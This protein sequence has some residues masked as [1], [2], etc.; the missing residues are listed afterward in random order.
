M[1]DS[2]I[3]NEAILEEE[4]LRRVFVLCSLNSVVYATYRQELNP[5]RSSEVATAIDYTV[6][7]YD[8]VSIRRKFLS[9]IIQSIVDQP[10]VR[11]D[12]SYITALFERW[13]LKLTE[14]QSFSYS[15]SVA[16]RALVKDTTKTAKDRPLVIIDQCPRNDTARVSF[17]VSFLK[18]SLPDLMGD[19]VYECTLP[20]YKQ[21]KAF[22]CISCLT[23]T[24]DC[25]TMPCNHVLLCE[26]CFN[27]LSPTKCLRCLTSIDKAAKI[28]LS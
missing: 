21:L 25:I 2:K 28:Y 18:S 16:Q 17:L 20:S 24:A 11:I 5:E 22:H 15:L 9:T 1:E 14:D 12:A 26:S 4:V 19:N 10:G 13:S 27:V 6:V 7:N 8:Y 23:E 3:Q